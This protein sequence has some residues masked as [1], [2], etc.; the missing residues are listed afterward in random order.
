M[1][2][3]RTTYLRTAVHVAGLLPLALIVIA[4]RTDNLTANPLQEVILRTGK[5]A[6]IF[7]TLSLTITPLGTVLGW[8]WLTPYRRTL[9][10]YAF[11]YGTLHFLSF[12]WLDYDF[13]LALIG[14]EVSE[15]RYILVGFS[16]F[17]L[18]LP[19]AIT[20]TKGWQRRLGRRWKQLHKWVYVA[21][22]LVVVHYTWLVKADTRQP[23]AWGAM[24]AV[25]LA[26]RL[27]SVRRWLGA[28][29]SRRATAKA[30]PEAT[31]LRLE[32]PR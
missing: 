8:R 29:R 32:P 10:L 23:L 14:A 1:S 26:L 7:L 9:G 4:A 21:A 31:D 17:L 15:K 25:L 11:L 30:R 24:I 12:S 6:L 20:S 18:L 13:D 27:A 5:A 22:I 16:A 3:F 2:R 28:R 19:L